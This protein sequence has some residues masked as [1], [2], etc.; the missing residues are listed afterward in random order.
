MRRK[1]WVM[2]DGL[3]VRENIRWRRGGRIDVVRVE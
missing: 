3:R 1:V 2:V